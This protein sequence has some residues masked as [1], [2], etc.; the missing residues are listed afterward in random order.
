[1]ALAEALAGL[2]GLGAPD[3]EGD[4]ECDLQE[5]TVPEGRGVAEAARDRDGL[6]EPLVL[7]LAEGQAERDKDGSDVEDAKEAVGLPEAG[8]LGKRGEWEPETD[9][10]SLR[11]EEGERLAQALGWALVDGAGVGSAVE[12]RHR[13]GVRLTDTLSLAVKEGGREFTLDTEAQCEAECDALAQ[14]LGW[15]LAD[16]GEDGSAEGEPHGVGEGL[17]GA[18]SPA[19]RDGDG[20][21]ELVSVA[22]RE[23]KRG[24]L[25]KALEEVLA[26]SEED[27]NTVVESQGE[28]VG[29]ANALMHAV[30]ESECVLDRDAVAQCE[31]L[32]H[33]LTEA[34]EDTEGDRVDNVAELAA[35]T[36]CEAKGEMLARALEEEL[37]DT[38]EDGSAEGESQGVGVRLPDTLM[39]AVLES[40][41]VLDSDA[42]AQCEALAQA[43]TEA[44]EDSEGVRVDSV[45][46]LAAVAQCEAEG[47]ALPEALGEALG[48][49]SDDGIAEGD[50]QGVGVR[51]P[52]TLM[53]TVL[54]SEC[55]LDSDAVAQCEALAQELTEAQEDADGESVT[56]KVA[57]GEDVAV[58]RALALT[59]LADTVAEGR[60]LGDSDIETES[61]PLDEGV[62]E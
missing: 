49:G 24:A 5:L 22:S 8:L 50:S 11:V 34:Q 9:P 51:L 33:E 31:A 59:W 56:E 39:Q 25:A 6:S 44:Q 38:S 42:V 61:V 4:L 2:D 55:V 40:E 54:E 23:G 7:E 18:L 35:V 58:A 17:T 60:L 27:C 36:L 15:V 41:C 32:A 26:E 14:A 10:V 45:A 30:L 47:E 43:L 20:A 48:D 57:Q 16:G 13:V 53:Q 46:E 29:L 62:V 12:D 28:G 3:A 21:L 19:V 1:M 37:E 52:D